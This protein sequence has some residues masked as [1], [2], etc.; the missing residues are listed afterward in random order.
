MTEI[1]VALFDRPGPEN[2]EETLRR[3][4]LRALELGIDHA[5]VASCSGE[6]ALKLHRTARELGYAGKLVA[7]TSHVGFSEPGVDDMGEAMRRRLRD[8][9]FSI[10][11]GTHA[12]SGPARSFRV[13]FQGFSAMDIVS[14]TLRLFGQGV[15]VCVECAVMAA[16]AGAVPVGRDVLFFGGTEGGVDAACVI[17]PAHQNN[18]LDLRVREIVAKPR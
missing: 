13:K 9:G 14:E 3:G 5:V 4:I 11:T 18:F 15:K 16:D 8:L 6:T 12:L 2:T 7:V 10:V 1:K 17:A